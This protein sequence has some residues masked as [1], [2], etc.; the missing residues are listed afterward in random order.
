MKGPIKTYGTNWRTHI[1]CYWQALNQFRLGLTSRAAWNE[2]AR[3]TGRYACFI[4]AVPA[5]GTALPHMPAH[6]AVDHLSWY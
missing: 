5:R 2:H 1:P 6:D 3:C 4:V